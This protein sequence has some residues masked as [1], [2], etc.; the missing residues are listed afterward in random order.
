[1]ALTGEQQRIIEDSLW[2]VGAVGKRL[3]VKDEDAR[4]EAVLYMIQCLD[5]FDPSKGVKWETYAYKNVYLYM[6]RTLKLKQEKESRTVEV[7]EFVYTPSSD[8]VEEEAI[9]RLSVEAVFAALKPKERSV[10]TLIAQGDSFASIAEMRGCS[11]QA[12]SCM[13]KRIKK[14]IQE[15]VPLSEV[16]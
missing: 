1:M 15:Q 3:R 8:N 16:K 11:H 4:S 13:W 5:R 10:A 2:I 12:V 6:S 7:E 14:K 9:R